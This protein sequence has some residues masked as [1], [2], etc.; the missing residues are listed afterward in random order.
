[1]ASV[2]VDRPRGVGP[3]GERRRTG[4][5]GTRVA[6]A[7]TWEA[8]R[9]TVLLPNCTGD[10]MSNLIHPMKW[11]FALP[12]AL[13]A[14]GSVAC[15]AEVTTR[16]AV[17]TAD[18]DVVVAA[19]PPNI[20]AYPHTVYRGEPVYYVDGRWYRRHGSHWGY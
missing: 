13:S 19:P 12:F 8:S 11:A 20:Y 17:V 16:P 10:P 5:R 18:E 1:M 7:S 15:S 6:Q 14:L 9:K 4:E 3:R 2:P